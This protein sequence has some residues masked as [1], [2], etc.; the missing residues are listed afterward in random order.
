[1]EEENENNFLFIRRMNNN[2]QINN[3]IEEILF[4]TKII[5]SILLLFLIIFLSI[6]TGN[7]NDIYHYN[8]TLEPNKFH[9]T[10]MYDFDLLE[11]LVN[12]NT[13]LIWVETPTNPMLN[14]IDLKIYKHIDNI[15]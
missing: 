14:I 2:N 8:Y 4:N 11:D 3:L 13:K 1:M 7:A 9:F 15:T 6:I 5:K 10:E 12:E